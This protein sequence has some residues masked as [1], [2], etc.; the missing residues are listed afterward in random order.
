HWDHP[1]V[2]FHCLEAALKGEWYRSATPEHVLIAEQAISDPGVDVALLPF[3]TSAR[4][5]VAACRRIRALASEM[6]R[7]GHPAEYEVG[8][9]FATLRRAE[10]PIAD[11]RLGQAEKAR[12]ERKLRENLLISAGILLLRARSKL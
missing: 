9:L 10:F 4:N 12:L 1:L 7:P 3:D 8:L 6:A 11:K 5:A 2:D